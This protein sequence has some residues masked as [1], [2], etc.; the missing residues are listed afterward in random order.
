MA[1]VIMDR[2]YAQLLREERAAAGA[3]RWDEVWA[4]PYMMAPLPN[5]EHQDLVGNLYDALR[6]VVNRESAL[7]LPG[8][9]VSDR[10]KGWER[11]YRCPDVVLYLTDTSAKNCDTHWCG[12]PDFAVEIASPDDATREK[13]DFYAQFGTRELLIV[14]RNPWQLELLRLEGGAL[15]SA[16]TSTIVNRQTL[17]SNVLP[18]SFSLVSGEARPTIQVVHGADGKTWNV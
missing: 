8:A 1:T 2:G 6:G 13:I 16:G 15:K 11:N 9:N 3:D 10:E 4:G 17:V 7:V 12:G 18:L 5:I 14:D